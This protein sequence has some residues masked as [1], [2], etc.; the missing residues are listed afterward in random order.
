MAVQWFKFYGAD[1]LSDPKMLSLSAEERSCWLTLL[2]FASQDGGTVRNMDEFKLMTQAGMDF[3]DE[4]WS[5]TTGVIKKFKKLKMIHIDNG[6]ITILHWRERQETSLSGY[7]RVKKWR[8]KKKND[9]NDNENDNV[10]IDKNRIDKNNT[11]ALSA[12]KEI[13]EIIFLF[14]E[15]NPSVQILYERKNQRQAVE[16]LLKL[17]GREKL[18]NTIAALKQINAMPYAPIATTPIQLEE[19]AGRIQ[20][21]IE[22]E[23]NKLSKNQ[24]VIIP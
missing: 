21:F 4:C 15:I 20:A 22:Q 16:R 8:E 24:I 14:K 7:E 2:C 6:L 18:E 12:G 10:R 3:E 19:K 17:W 5:N 9:N 1:Y 11:Y 13:A 23:K